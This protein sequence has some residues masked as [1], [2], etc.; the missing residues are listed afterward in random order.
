[1]IWIWDWFA[2]LRSLI[3]RAVLN[4]PHKKSWSSY[5]CPLDKNLLT[6]I[7]LFFADIIILSWPLP[8]QPTLPIRSRPTLYPHTK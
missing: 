4:F 2:F 6:N 3:W 8:T 7:L 1:V 5:A